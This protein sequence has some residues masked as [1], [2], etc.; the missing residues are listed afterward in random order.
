MAFWL[1]SAEYE[2]NNAIQEDFE[3]CF[4]CQLQ[5]PHGN[6]LTKGLGAMN[7]FVALATICGTI[8]TAGCGL[9]PATGP[10]AIGVK[11][12]GTWNGP[13]YGLVYI[14]PKTVKILDE[15]GPLSLSGVFGDRRP[16][17]DITFGIGDVVS[18]TIFE[19]AAGGL[20]IPSEA[21]VRPGNFVALPNQPIDTK[22]FISVP[23]AVYPGRGKTLLWCLSKKLSTGSKTERSS[24]RLWWRSLRRIPRSLPSSAR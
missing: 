5:T 14:T 1:L 22:G 20:F 3:I 16:P 12:G 15:F 13:A 11:L 18:V 2:P 9:L 24:R 8:L 6:L 10:N 4:Y 19:A 23:Y 21:G 17:P 7:R